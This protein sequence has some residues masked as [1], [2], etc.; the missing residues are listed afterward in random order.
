MTPRPNVQTFIG[1]AAP[2]AEAGAVI[3]GAPF[4]STASFRPGARFG[5][6]AIRSESSG[7][8][9]YSAYQD[10]DLEDCKIFD[11]GDLELPF[12]N[13]A[14]ALEIIES[15]VSDVVSA[16]KI[17][18]M[19]GGEHL[20]TLG[21]VSA[22]ASVCPGLNVIHFDAHADLRDEY[23][24]ERLSHATVMRRVLEILNGGTLWQ[25]GI[26]SACRNELRETDGLVRREMF[27]LSGVVSAAREI[28]RAPVYVSIDLDVLD[29]AEFPGT[30]T[31]EAGGVS[32]PAL[33]ES[34]LALRG[35][36]VK[37]F[38]LCELAP[39]YDHS[40]RS[41]ALACKIMRETLLAFSAV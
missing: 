5:P 4:D 12:G 31:P 38:D 16:G 18:C 20:V 34:V 23:L 37:G 10:R 1:C 33:L 15:F 7:L 30:G 36:D 32:F 39:H 24:G 21:A 22:I 29:P 40:G 25:F 14:K 17:S 27:G 26:R 3:F 19:T 8:E 13:A 6:A 35:L 11:A 2:F 41:T 9:T 28:G